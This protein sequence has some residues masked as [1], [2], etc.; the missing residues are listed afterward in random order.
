[1]SSLKDF[2]GFPL[3]PINAAAHGESIDQLLA[4][5]HWFMFALFVFWTTFFFYTLI[6]F[7]ASRNPKADYDGLK[8]KFPKYLEGAVVAIEVVL[9]F[10]FS[11]P[12]W[13]NWTLNFPD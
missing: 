12:L 13:A 9:L 3:L 6:R 10:G 8:S 5:L 11:I 2:M 7:R 4:Y 1:M